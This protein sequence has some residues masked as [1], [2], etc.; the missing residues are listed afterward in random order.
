M[1]MW[2][3]GAVPVARGEVMACRRP[4]AVSVALEEE[5]EREEGGGSEESC[6]ERSDDLRFFLCA[7]WPSWSERRDDTRVTRTH[8]HTHKTHKPIGNNTSK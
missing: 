3:L 8:T 2:G 7:G 4:M 6:G 5:E 1:F